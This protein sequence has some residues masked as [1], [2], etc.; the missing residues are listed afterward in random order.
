MNDFI[1]SLKNEGI[2][3]N[4]IKAYSGH[5]SQYFN[6]FKDSFGH[7]PEKLY[8]ENII[9]YKSFLLNIKNQSGKTVN[10]KL[11]ALNKYNQ[12]LVDL[13]IQNSIVITKKDF[14]KIQVQY[15]SPTTISK[16]EVDA[17]RQ[18][19][20]ENEPKR[21]YAIVTLLTYS[22]LRISEALNLKKNDINLTSKEIIVKSGKGD[23]QRIVIINDKII[24]ATKEYLKE[25][26]TNHF[27]DSENLFVSRK[28][29]KVDKSTINKVFQKYSDKITPHSLRHYFCTLALE[30]NWSV[31]EVASQVGHSNIHTTLLY[32][33]PSIEMMKEKANR[34]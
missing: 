24:I 22:G 19:I 20:L 26:E 9:E 32:T 27:K 31:H 8:R 7:N 16:K 30:N 13:K 34:L 6:W 15:A 10:A 2:S 17:F 23:K 12:F 28:S 21:N 3:I 1:D 11:S 4:T 18:N 29:D 14:V 5:I 25:R 33:N